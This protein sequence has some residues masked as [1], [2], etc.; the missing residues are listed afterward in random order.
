[1]D[2]AAEYRTA[3]WVFL[4]FVV[5]FF[6]FMCCILLIMLRGFLKLRGNTQ[7]KAELQKAVHLDSKDMFC[8][9][10]DTDVGNAFVYGEL[11][12]VDPVFVPELNGEYSC[13]SYV[14]EQKVKKTREGT[15]S[16]Y[17]NGKM[18]T[19]KREEAYYEW[20]EVFSR[21]ANCKQVT[22]MDIEFPYEK[23]PLQPEHV[24]KTST[25]GDRRY[26]WKVA[27]AVMQ[28]SMKVFL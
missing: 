28:E 15:E 13:V 4:L 3:V 20:K 18:E 7:R 24:A 26:T 10:M 1:M 16:V 25:I 12:A 21:N 22:F 11:R 27:P 17:R 23:I 19:V 14:E 2:M 6:L 9:G 8:Y 5:L